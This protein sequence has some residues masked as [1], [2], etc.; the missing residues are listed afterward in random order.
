MFDHIIKA[1]FQK[2]K[3]TE[4]TDLLWRCLRL[5]GTTAFI[6]NNNSVRVFIVRLFKIKMYSSR[7]FG[8][9]DYQYDRFWNFD[10]A[11]CWLWQEHFAYQ[12]QVPFTLEE[13]VC[14]R[15]RGFFKEMSFVSCLWQ[16]WGPWKEYISL[17]LC[18]I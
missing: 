12:L 2:S 18:G 3:Q 6:L 9:H 5:N 15:A 10:P 16:N 11:S 1:Q 7:Q 14:P 4:I 17:K 8:N 13:H